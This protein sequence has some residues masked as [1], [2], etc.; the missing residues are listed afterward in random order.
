MECRRWCNLIS[1]APKAGPRANGLT[2]RRGKERSLPQVTTVAGE[3][4]GPLQKT[5]WLFGCFQ[6]IGGFPPKSFNLIG[7]SI[8]NHPFWGTPI[9]GNTHFTTGGMGILV[10][11]YYETLPE[12]GPRH[13]RKALEN[14]E[15]LGDGVFSLGGGK[16]HIFRAEV[17]VL[18]RVFIFFIQLGNVFVDSTRLNVRKP[19]YPGIPADRLA[20][21]TMRMSVL[22][23]A[24]RLALV[25][26]ICLSMF[27]LGTAIESRAGHFMLELTVERGHGVYCDVAD[28]P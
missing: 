27:F 14:W 18:G 7:F 26:L 16:R 1:R 12:M 11:T 2:P 24:H 8:I 21:E 20:M 28:L 6:K 5:R 4:T 22:P 23:L 13:S 3:F 15:M 9:F 25:N 17:F 19:G 10:W